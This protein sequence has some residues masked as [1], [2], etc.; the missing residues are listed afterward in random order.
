MRD[1]YFHLTASNTC[2]TIS[3][4][5]Y[6]SGAMIHNYYELKNYTVSKYISA[7]GYDDYD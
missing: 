2:Y 5:V 6:L 4:N 1:N 7:S 3:A